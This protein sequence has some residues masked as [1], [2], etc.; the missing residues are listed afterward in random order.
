MNCYPQDSLYDDPHLYQDLNKSF[1]L[2]T[3]YISS[4]LHF[5]VIM[6]SNNARYM[7]YYY[8]N[9]SILW[10]KNV[11]KVFKKV[12]F[13]IIIKLGKFLNFDF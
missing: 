9:H 11:Q 7:D 12:T 3:F 13:F 6:Y 2:Y 1:L 8:M 4:I 5:T 10:D